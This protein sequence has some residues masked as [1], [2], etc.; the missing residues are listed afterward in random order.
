VVN[1]TVSKLVSRSCLTVA[2]SLVALACSDDAPAGR[3]TTKLTVWVLSEPVTN[4]DEPRPLTGVDVA[5][6]P[7]GGGARVTRKTDADG[8]VDFDGDFDAG[9]G[10]VT[11]FSVEHTLVSRL[12]VSPSSVAAR[13][14]TF[15]KPER[16]LVIV[17]PRLDTAVRAASCELRGNVTG[18]LDSAHTVSI[19]ASTLLRLGKSSTSEPAYTLRAPTGRPFFLLGHEVG[20][21]RSNDTTVAIE[22]FKTFRVDVGPLSADKMLDIDLAALPALPVR[23]VRLHGEAPSGDNGTFGVG[24]RASGAITSVDSQVVTGV[25]TRGST[26]S[27]GRAFDVEL[28]VSDVD[29]APE[30][31]FTQAT[32]VAPNGALSIRQELGAVADGTSWTDFPA[33]PSVPDASRTLADAIPLDG[34]PQGADLRIEVFANQQLI[35]ILEGPPG[36]PRE[37]SF[38]LPAPL[39]VSFSADVQLVAVSIAAELDRVELAPHGELYRRIAVAPDVMLRRR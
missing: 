39:G 2:V 6:D 3:P 14:N 30:R 38:V 27:E 4:S 23:T 10:R 16:D 17:L 32:L 29:V 13:P 7:P 24:S 37:K 18:K 9:S 20:P 8:H 11:A 36:G 12:E 28:A 31:L 22:H 33:P 21:L 35:W 1:T 25:F 19:A 34:F 5:F 15:G 26:T